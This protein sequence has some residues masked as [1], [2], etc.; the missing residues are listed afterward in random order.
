MNITDPDAQQNLV[1]AIGS[2]KFGTDPQV[3][4]ALAI[5]LGKINITDRGAQQRLTGA[6]YDGKFGTDPEVL[7]ALAISLGE[8]NITAEGAQHNL[9]KAILESPI[10]IPGWSLKYILSRQ[11]VGEQV[12]NDHPEL[13]ATHFFGKFEP[14]LLAKAKED[15]KN[16][17]MIDGVSGVSTMIET[18]FDINGVS[19]GYNGKIAGSYG[20]IYD[21]DGNPDYLIVLAKK[22]DNIPVQTIAEE[23]HGFFNMTKNT[24]PIYGSLLQNVRVYKLVNNGLI[25]PNPSINVISDS[26]TGWLK[27]AHKLSKFDLAEYN[28][29]N[30]LKFALDLTDNI[31]DPELRDSTIKGIQLL[32][33]GEGNQIQLGSTELKDKELKDKIEKALPYGEIVG[34]LPNSN[35]TRMEEFWATLHDNSSKAKLIFLLGQ[36]AKK[37]ALGYELGGNNRANSFYYLMTLEFAKKFRKEFPDNSTEP[38]AVSLNHL[39]H[40]LKGGICIEAASNSFMINNPTLMLN[41]VWKKN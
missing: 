2:D 6:I 34:D 21:K 41:T 16:T 38:L 39:I 20:F 18:F 11:I 19:S 22:A 15:E 10:N 37:G 5:S 4:T 26:L 9:T 1:I 29:Q 28:D 14:D 24:Y 8:M 27:N 12:R 17:G 33:N 3:L 35:K 23:M 32:I 40:D 31:A 30:L 7:K 13:N 36:I 25:Y